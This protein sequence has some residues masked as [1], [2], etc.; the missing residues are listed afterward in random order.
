MQFQTVELHLPNIS[1][2]CVCCAWEFD[3][4][5]ASNDEYDTN[6]P[7]TDITP[8][9][10]SMKIYITKRT[11]KRVESERKK[12]ENEG[13][14][15]R[16]EWDRRHWSKEMVRR[17]LCARRKQKQCFEQGTQCIYYLLSQNKTL[18][19]HSNVFWKF[20]PVEPMRSD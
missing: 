15:W 12:E 10:K 7:H 4:Q 8:V 6:S 9:I 17:D 16:S 20:G 3:V 5:L 13:K 14:V 18:K 1:Y 2:A 19:F 11:E